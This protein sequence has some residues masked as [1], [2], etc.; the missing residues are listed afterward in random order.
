MGKT[1][2]PNNIFKNLNGSKDLKMF[3]NNSRTDG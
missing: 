1:D 3:L 2:A